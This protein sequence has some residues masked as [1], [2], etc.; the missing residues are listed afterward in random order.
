MS[1]SK[2]KLST[3]RL[4][5]D[6]VMTFKQ[7][8]E[9]EKAV[10]SGEES[11]VYNAAVTRGF[12][13]KEQLDSCVRLAK[14]PSSNPYAS[15]K[16]VQLVSAGLVTF[17]QLN[18][19][20]KEARVSKGKKSVHDVL[21]AKGYVSQADLEKLLDKSQVVKKKKVKETTRALGLVKSGVIS[22][23]QL[24]EVESLQRIDPTQSLSN[25]LIDHGYAS[26]DD[27]AELDATATAAFTLPPPK[28]RRTA[29]D[30]QVPDIDTD[31]DA[32][33]DANLGRKK[34]KPKKKYPTADQFQAA[35]TEVGAGDEDFNMAQTF[36]EAEPSGDAYPSFGPSPEL[37]S[38]DFEAQPTFMEVDDQGMPVPPQPDQD[39][40]DVPTDVDFNDQAQ[41]FIDMEMGSGS[42]S[43]EG[44]MAA[45]V[46]S[47]SESTDSDFSGSSSAGSGSNVLRQTFMDFGDASSSENLAHRQAT[48]PASGIRRRRRS[49]SS[50]G[51]TS[52]SGSGSRSS[53]TGR[54][55]RAK[56]NHPL[57]GETLGGC[58]IGKLLGQGGMGAVFKARHLGLKRDVAI[59]VISPHLAS[60]QQ[61]IQRFIREARSAA[62]LNH[63][64][65]VAVHNV[66]NEKGYH[67]IEMEYV[68]GKGLDEFLKEKGP[69]GIEH[70]ISIIRDAAE[71]LAVA[72]EKGIVHRDIKP[73]NLM[74]TEKNKAVKITDFGLAR[75]GSE[76][77]E[78]TKVGQIL[79]T[80]AY[81]SPEQCAGEK[82]DSRS[83]IYSL[84][85]TF[86]ALV[87]GKMPFIGDSA[88]EIMQKHL[89]QDPL[90][91]RE[92]NP[93]IPG[94]VVQTVYK[95]MSKRPEDR[96]Q[97]A[98]DI[99]KALDRIKREEGKEKIAEIQI[100]IGE[101]Y[102]I[103]TKLGQGGMGAVYKATR[104]KDKHDVAIKVLSME[105]N[106]EELGRFKREAE[107]AG[108][109]DHPNV[110]KVLD[111]SVGGEVNYIVMEYVAGTSIRD[112]I[113]NEGK[114]E[115]REVT[116]ILEET[117]KGMKAAHEKGIVHRDIKPDN[118]MVSMESGAIKIADFG[119]AREMDAQ[120]EV[121]RAGFILGTPHYMS[122]EQCKGLEVDHRADI[123][124]LG[125]SVYF[126]LTG[127]TP[128]AGDTQMTIMLQHLKTVPP[129]VH[130]V[131]ED[132]PEGMSNLVA[133]MMAKKAKY[134]YQDVDEIAK[135]LQRLRENKKVAKRRRVDEVYDESGSK[136]TYAIFA[137]VALVL[138]S[139]G[140]FFGL[141]QWNIYQQRLAEQQERDAAQARIERQTDQANKKT[142]EITADL[143]KALAD[144]KRLEA[145][146][147]FRS[148]V[149]NLDTLV[150]KHKVLPSDS[151]WIVAVKESRKDELLAALEE[152]ESKQ[153]Q[154]DE[155][156]ARVLDRIVS[157]NFETEFADRTSAMTK[158]QNGWDNTELDWEEYDALDKGLASVLR[159]NM[160]LAAD[161]EKL[162]DHELNV[163]YAGTEMTAVEYK[164]E[165]QRLFE[166]SAQNQ[167]RML[168]L[169]ANRLANQ[170][171]SWDQAALR[172]VDFIESEHYKGTPAYAAVVK[173]KAEYDE[174]E[175]NLP[176]EELKARNDFRLIKT[177]FDEQDGLEDLIA[178]SDRLATFLGDYTDVDFWWNE[179]D[180]LQP[181]VDRAIGTL[182][183]ET[184]VE[185]LARASAARGEGNY[186]R[187]EEIL[188]EKDQDQNWID[189]EELTKLRLEVGKVRDEARDKAVTQLNDAEKFI[190]LQQYLRADRIL[191]K[192][193]DEDYAQAQWTTI[194]RM[195]DDIEDF[196]KLH[197]E[198]SMV[199]I[200]AGSFPFG[201]DDRTRPPNSRP[202]N[203]LEMEDAYFIDRFEVSVGNYLDFMKHLQ[204]AGVKVDDYDDDGTPSDLRGKHKPAAWDSA[205]N[206]G[207]GISSLDLPVTGVTYWDALAYANWCGKRIPTEQEWEKAA[208][209]GPAAEVEADKYIFPWGNSF[210]RNLCSCLEQYGTEGQIGLVRSKEDAFDARY[211]GLAN[212]TGNVWEWTLGFRNEQGRT[213]FQAYPRSDHRERAYDEGMRVVRGGS[214]AVSDYDVLA[215]ETTFRMPEKPE[216]RKNDIGF[217]CVRDAYE[218]EAAGK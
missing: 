73:E 118:I 71:G 166:E 168:D 106:E 170:R 130:E 12:A 43:G 63:K 180:R 108:S 38:E 196:V 98:K 145:E 132:V 174:L 115:T 167:K 173:K 30:M 46:G 211:K 126:M 191:A 99:V 78:L 32:K 131:C 80:P 110:V 210:D 17:K 185:I 189:T 89:D 139:V 159:T 150:K 40:P 184:L 178:V 140:G 143:E 208:S 87:T 199:L 10:L 105:V 162:G 20:D 100:A 97:S 149:R 77:Q 124:S 67:F 212:M 172:Y 18:E 133:N 157:Q 171:R 81:M 154:R 21:L 59:K 75:G 26:E 215:F 114:L 34:K 94:S 112:M 23:K 54:R 57:I 186:S 82:V 107:T 148:T 216:T 153:R 41:T 88:L 200:A 84:G 122:P 146:S 86:Y 116:A 2:R 214:Y 111:Y 176:R 72:H 53:D 104:L 64:S 119:L 50:S 37:S 109:I 69:F 52:S 65:I 5:K 49:A 138:I 194:R 31:R 7:L 192:L 175:A 197:G 135:D 92:Y 123:Y 79:G 35:R 45:L 90:N 136:R 60:N 58:Q 29:R 188:A 3:A 13:K 156:A 141:R 190:G 96:Y 24:K 14:G 160:T 33:T 70:A 39:Y 68:K 161:L 9:C 209:W 183:K 129:M 8:N 164:A 125:V 83:D 134:R 195:R 91:P 137:M 74:L 158:K 218:L 187:A 11:D 206:P 177:L 113:R 25:L 155:S 93:D 205:T 120:S 217:R 117:L 36:I 128:F 198:A 1:R 203:M 61:L 151:S 142:L 201:T 16:P 42:E 62:E 48:T 179:A 181:K 4:L 169:R 204:A 56:K 22:F 102:K 55:S 193:L 19:C 127:Q 202:Q 27:V 213:G 152:Y 47:G 207:P 6:G 144:A 76:M 15:I 182:R 66:G 85:A 121:T 163:L 147:Q 95:M 101:H 103:T 44:G 165:L 51:G 28:R